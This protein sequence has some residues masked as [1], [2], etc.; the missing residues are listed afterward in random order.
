MKERRAPP[1]D[2]FRAKRPLVRRGVGNL[3][4]DVGPVLV[5]PLEQRRDRRVAIAR[6]SGARLP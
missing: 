5:Q 3:G 4:R 6:T 2:V 1:D